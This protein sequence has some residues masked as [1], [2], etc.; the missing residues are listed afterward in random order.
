MT[1]RWSEYNH[2]ASGNGFSTKQIGDHYP[3]KLGGISTV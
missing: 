1:L 2:Q 3:F